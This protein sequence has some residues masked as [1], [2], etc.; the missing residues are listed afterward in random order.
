MSML[1]H[2][3]ATELQCGRLGVSPLPTPSGNGGLCLLVVSFNSPKQVDTWGTVILKAL[4][5]APAQPFLA[6]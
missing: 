3:F 6:N 2:I 5:S 1:F 4:S